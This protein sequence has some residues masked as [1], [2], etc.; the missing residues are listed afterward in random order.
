[1]N[2]LVEEEVLVII[3][4]WASFILTILL[5]IMFYSTSLSPCETKSG[6]SIIPLTAL[7][8]HRNPNL[9]RQHNAHFLRKSIFVSSMLF[10][11][12]LITNAKNS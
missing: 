1:M 3:I 9:R 7:Y 4:Q 2:E 12:N 10:A 11:N 5:E 8:Y 6:H